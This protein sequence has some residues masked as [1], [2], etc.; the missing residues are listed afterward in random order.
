M[1]NVLSVPLLV[2][3]AFARGA[4]SSIWESGGVTAGLQMVK[5]LVS[6]G[7]FVVTGHAAEVYFFLEVERGISDLNI[8]V[9][10]IFRVGFFF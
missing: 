7:E 4:M 10:I 3:F 5:Q 9:W 1:N 2:F 8:E 6:C